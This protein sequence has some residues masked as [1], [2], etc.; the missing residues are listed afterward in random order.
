MQRPTAITEPTMQCVDDTGIFA[1]DATST[2]VAV[3]KFIEYAL[4]GVIAVSLV[5]TVA[6]T[7]AP[8]RAR[9]QTTPK[10]HTKMIQ[11]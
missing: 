4:D 2:A 7:F 8:Q 11:K 3:P 5:P 6:M 10:Q 1:N 9:P